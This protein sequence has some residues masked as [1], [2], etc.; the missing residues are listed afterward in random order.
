MLGFY[1]FSI[2]SLLL[3]KCSCIE[4]MHFDACVECVECELSLLEDA[5]SD[6]PEK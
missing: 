3:V 6:T 4:E 5:S 1:L 2:D